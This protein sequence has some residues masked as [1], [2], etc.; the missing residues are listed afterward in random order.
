MEE[1]KEWEEKR[2]RERE[3]EENIYISKKIYK[4]KKNIYT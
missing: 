2:G 3:R 4:Y 1:G